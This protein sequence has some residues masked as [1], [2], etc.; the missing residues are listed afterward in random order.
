M[1]MARREAESALQETINSQRSMGMK[2][3]HWD[4]YAI[5]RNVL[6]EEIGL[7]GEPP[8]ESYHFSQGTYEVL[9][10]HSRQDVAHALCNTK[11]LLDLNQKISSRLGTLNF[12]AWIISGLLLLLVAKSHPQFFSGL[13]NL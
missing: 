8:R 11:S 2:G 4:N 12:L 3:E 6:Q 13:F 1:E 7:H 10:A 5:A 9:L